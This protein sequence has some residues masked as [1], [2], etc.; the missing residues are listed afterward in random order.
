MAP[1]QDK[2]AMDEAEE[3]ITYER[4]SEL[5]C[6]FDDVDTEMLAKQYLLATPVHKKLAAIVPKIPAFW[7]LVFEQSPPEIDTYIQPSDSAV[8]AAALKS[9]HV[10]RFEIPATAKP[11]DTGVQAFGEP[12]SFKI[13]FTF[14]ENEW[15]SD[16]TLEKKFYYRYAKDGFQGHISEPVKINWKPGKD[17]TDGMT[18]LAGKFYA[19]QLKHVQANGGKWG[20]YGKTKKNA[21]P[22]IEL[23]EFEEIKKRVDDSTEGSQSFFTWFGYRGKF[24]SEEENKAARAEE[25][26]R[27]AKVQR[28]EPLDDSDEEDDEMDEDGDEFDMDY[29]DSEVFFNGEDFGV[30]IAEELW[31]NAIQLFM[32]AQEADDLSEA[33]FEDEDMDDM[34]EEDDDED[35]DDDEE[36]APKA[37]AKASKPK[38]K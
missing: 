37:K 22:T 27:R 1:P 36:E 6:M 38:R 2:P 28:G 12:R 14:G 26:E 9:I 25:A 13:T 4:L 17:L 35:D 11:T 5:E 20:V 15:F 16:T 34:M 10:E 24:I 33:D 19:A 7:A 3:K 8:L 21:L 32:Q 31:P 18:D 23:P 29:A 30:C